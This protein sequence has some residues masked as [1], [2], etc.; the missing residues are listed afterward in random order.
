MP[1]IRH[2]GTGFPPPWILASTPI[3][4]LIGISDT[5]AGPFG[6]ATPIRSS[7]CLGSLLFAVGMACFSP[8]LLVLDSTH[9]GLLLSVRSVV[10]LG[11]VPLVLDFV[12]LGFPP[13]LRSPS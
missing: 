6:L 12:H 3:S 8:S 5:S 2:A 7:G 13:F 4:H 10:R 9:S 1:W 11:L